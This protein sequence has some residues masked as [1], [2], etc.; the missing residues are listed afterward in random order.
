MLV[1]A[2]FGACALLIAR[3]DE[4]QTRTLAGT[5]SVVDGDTLTISGVRVRLRGIDAFERDQLC[6]RGDIEYHCGLEARAALVEM[7]AGG[8][9]S[10]SGRTHDRYGRLLAV[11][12]AGSVDM[13]AAMVEAGWAL[14]YGQYEAEEKRARL[15]RRGAWSGTF[16][17]PAE[18]RA[19]DGGPVEAT[20]GLLQT[21]FDL[22]RQL[23]AGRPDGGREDEAL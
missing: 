11:C 12:T 2:I 4:V 14:A 22:L 15:A 23:L 20:Q 6:R 5:G 18:W 1:A 10:C 3:L 8:P 7:A 13:S 16:D 21:V 9:V 19:A 17:D